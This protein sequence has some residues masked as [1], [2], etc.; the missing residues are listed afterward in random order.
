M[1][2]NSTYNLVNGLIGFCCSLLGVITQFQEE[3]DAVL[4]TSSTILLCCVSIVTLYNQI[5]KKKQ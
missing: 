2:E 4:K 5:K 1:N 3:L